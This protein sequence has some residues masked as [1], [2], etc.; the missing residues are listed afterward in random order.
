MSILRLKI[1]RKVFYGCIALDKSKFY[2][3]ARHKIEKNI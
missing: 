1:E 2:I 3:F